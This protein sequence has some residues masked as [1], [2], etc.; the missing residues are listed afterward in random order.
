MLPQEA[1]LRIFATLATLKSL[2]GGLI[3]S[4]VARVVTFPEPLVV[5]AR[6]AARDRQLPAWVFAEAQRLPVICL[7][8]D[9][10]P[11]PAEERGQTW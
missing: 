11:R 2:E 10:G 7:P 5:G 3:V 4:H 1:G 9:V 8:A 6:V